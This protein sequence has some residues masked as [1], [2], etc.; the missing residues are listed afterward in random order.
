LLST[1]HLSSLHL[2]CS[3]SHAFN[4]QDPFLRSSFFV[5]FDDTFHVLSMISCLGILRVT[6]VFVSTPLLYISMNLGIFFSSSFY[7]MSVSA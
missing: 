7:F 5:V 2:H 6:I 4:S 1:W 3:Q